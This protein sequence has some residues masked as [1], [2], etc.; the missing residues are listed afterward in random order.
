MKKGLFNSKVN[1]RKEK[2]DFIDDEKLKQIK[3]DVNVLLEMKKCKIC[4]QNKIIYY[5]R[6]DKNKD[7]YS[8]ICLECNLQDNER[9]CI[10]CNKTK[11]L[12]DF[13]TIS[14][15]G[16]TEYCKECIKEIVDKYQY[17][18]KCK[19]CKKEL[20]AT[21]KYFK[22]AGHYTEYLEHKCRVCRG[23]KY[24]EE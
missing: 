12:S 16:Y 18:K 5:F 11:D 9:V 24:L 21:S 14:N 17:L 20:P 23:L 19:K 13:Y 1:V 8:D 15:R 22:I 3:N 10:R 4:K 2:N 7:E 6:I